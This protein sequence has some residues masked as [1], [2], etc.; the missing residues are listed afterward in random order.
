MNRGGGLV[1][2][3]VRK[4]AL[5]LILAACS[6][7]AP[8]SPVSLAPLPT[9]APVTFPPAPEVP[10]G[11]LLPGT[12]RLLD[13]VWEGLPTRLA[14]DEI[15]ALGHTGDARVAWA[16]ADLMQFLGLGAPADSALAAAERLIGAEIPPGV[17]WVELTNHLIAWD[18]PAFPDYPRYKARIF[19]LAD[20]TWEV[21]FTSPGEIDWRLVAFGGV[22]A[23]TRP[24]GDATPCACIPALDDPAVTPASEG[25]WLADEAVVFGVV[26]NGEARAYPRHIMETHEL[27]NDTL[28]GRRFALAYCTLCGSAQLFFTDAPGLQPP[29]LMRTSGLLHRSN[30]VMFDLHSWSLFD[31]FRGRAVAGPLW[32]RGVVLEQ[33]PVV[34]SSW[35]AWRASHPQTTIVAEDG[36]IGRRYS[37]D[38]LRGR[39]DEGPIFPIGDRDPRLPAQE[40]V[41]GVVLPDGTALAFPATAA[42]QA[43][44]AGAP[45]ELAGVELRLDGD[46][47]RAVL[48]GGQPLASH[49]AYW[50][51]WS[52]FHPQTLLWRG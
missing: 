35:G 24:R 43:L 3:D 10:E 25:G 28:G 16:L 42:R 41:V 44:E 47:L 8:P 22:L 11:P 4:L 13:L 30:K 29:P 31:T 17:P 49:Q 32:E 52:Q 51:A 18:L 7:A 39:D 20:P 27:V 23:D 38:P 26:V 34:T 21:F 37:L 45:V 9:A 19:T 2:E 1:H 50:F 46:G 33:A 48:P 5:L 14:T 36:G 12:N 6:Q 15:E 40:Q